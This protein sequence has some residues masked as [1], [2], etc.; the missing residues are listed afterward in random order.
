[1]EGKV[2]FG[3]GEN[4]GDVE[5]RG[6]VV[7]DSN[8]GSSGDLGRREKIVV[9]WWGG[10]RGA[11]GTDINDGTLK[12]TLGTL[13][14]HFIGGRREDFGDAAGA[15]PSNDVVGASSGT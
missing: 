13:F 9:R 15:A 6:G 14:C 1:M 5:A 8:D 10:V 4:F 12:N 11:E 3:V 7:A 2:G